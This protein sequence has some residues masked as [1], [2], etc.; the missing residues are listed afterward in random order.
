[1]H[2]PITEATAAIIV[3]AEFEFDELIFELL[4]LFDFEVVDNVEIEDVDDWN[5]FDFVGEVAV[6]V[7]N[8][9]E[10]SDVGPDKVE[11]TDVESI[12]EVVGD[13]AVGVVNVVEL[14]GPDDNVEVDWKAL[15]VVD[16]VVVSDIVGIVVVVVVDDVVGTVVVV[17]VVI[18]LHWGG[19]PLHP[20]VDWHVAVVAPTKL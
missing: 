11:V 14:V 20:P 4:L 10:L 19:E 18:R 7:V 3:V 17:V 2:I 9:V 13:V 15:L 16:D 1:M 12:V 5:V 8:V 6:G